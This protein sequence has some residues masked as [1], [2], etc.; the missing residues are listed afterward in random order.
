MYPP[1]RAEVGVTLNLVPSLVSAYVP[2]KAKA[3]DAHVL[4]GKYEEPSLEA[5]KP[6]PPRIAGIP[7]DIPP[8]SSSRLLIEEQG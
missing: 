8:P 6:V 7:Q 1:M 3:F 2:E 4:V 5:R